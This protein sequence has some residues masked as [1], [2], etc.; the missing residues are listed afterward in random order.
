MKRETFKI[1]INAAAERVWEVLWSDNYYRRWAAV[2]ME[3]SL[4]QTDWKEGS[5]VLFVS[6]EGE[7]MVSSIVSKKTNE[8]MVFRHL[9]TISKGVE[10]LDN[11]WT[12][13]MESYK[14]EANGATTLTVEMDST[15]EYLEYFKK[16]WPKALDSIKELAEKDSPK[17]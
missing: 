13:A 6:P 8:H 17:G 10:D 5:K 12:G 2:F 16:A 9:G 7:G 11:E 3:G 14:L 15:E 1:T 4:A